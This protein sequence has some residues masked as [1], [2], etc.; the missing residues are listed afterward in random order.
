MHPLK[1][2]VAFFWIRLSKTG[3]TRKKETG[4]IQ[5]FFDSVSG[6]RSLPGSGGK[7]RA[8]VLAC[9]VPHTRGLFGVESNF[10][11]KFLR[12]GSTIRQGATSCELHYPGPADARTTLGK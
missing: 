6:G 4:P 1:R 12:N 5:N 9:G 2:P 3:Y 7:H 11:L 8:L 10:E